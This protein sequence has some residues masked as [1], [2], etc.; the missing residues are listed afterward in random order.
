MHKLSKWLLLWHR[1]VKWLLLLQTGKE[2]VY[3]AVACDITI[4]MVEAG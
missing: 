1:L 4:A 3:V 2:T